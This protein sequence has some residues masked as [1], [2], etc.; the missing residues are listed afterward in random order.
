M[1]MQVTNLIQSI[2]LK[3]SIEPLHWKMKTKAKTIMS[4]DKMKMPQA[5]M[6][7]LPYPT[8]TPPSP[9]CR[10]LY[11]VEAFGS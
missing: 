8:H 1:S 10:V 3:Y 2:E 11:V 9:S 4:N 7:R 5:V 6:N